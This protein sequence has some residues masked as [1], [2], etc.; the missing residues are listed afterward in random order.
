MDP[1]TNAPEGAIRFENG[2][3]Y[4]DT[5]TEKGNT[6]TYS[7][8][9]ERGVWMRPIFTG[10]LW[11]V[12]KK[13]NDMPGGA[14]DKFILTVYIDDAIPDDN[15]LPVLT[16]H[17]TN[18]GADGQDW[19]SNFVSEVINALKRE[20]N[21]NEVPMSHVAKEP[22]DLALTFNNLDGPQVWAIRDDITVTVRIRADF[23][24]L[25]K[26]SLTNGF[27]QTRAL[28]NYD[29][30]GL[31][32]QYMVKVWTDSAGNLYSDIAP[33]YSGFTPK[34][35]MEMIMFGP[36]AVLAGQDMTKPVSAGELSEFV[37]NMEAYPLFDLH[38][39]P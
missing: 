23:K 33:N 31:T 15:L 39:A 37:L 34:Q 27:H 24:E 36:S 26:N 30:Q 3:Y 12:E 9:T 10:P 4:M 13:F 29:D 8:D 28:P 19:T 18:G 5:T 22:F 20:R 25:S 38:E 7:F 32:Y 16:H 35:L 17:E 1:M 11:D 2:L 6:L 14:K 21:S